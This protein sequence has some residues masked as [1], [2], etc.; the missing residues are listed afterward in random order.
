[1]ATTTSSAA[2]PDEHLARLEATARTIQKTVE[3]PATTVDDPNWHTRPH[4]LETTEHL[5]SRRAGMAE[6]ATAHDSAE[7]RWELASIDAELSRRA[8]VSPT[9]KA[10]EEVARGERPRAETGGT[11]AEGLAQEKAIR[12][13]ALPT[14]GHTLAE[15]ELGTLTHGVSGHTAGTYWLQHQHTP[16]AM[17]TILDAHHTDIGEL[18]VLRGKQLAT[19]RP[20]WAEALGEVPANPANAARWY[21]VAG[22][23]DAYRETYRI[24]DQT[25]IPKQYAESERGAYL[26]GQITDVHKRGALSHTP[27][28]DPE[29]VETTAA[30]ATRERTHRETVTPAEVAV[31]VTTEERTQA[32]EDLWDVVERDYKAEQ[33]AH[34]E[35]DAAREALEAARA[36]L[37]DSTGQREAIAEQLIETA[38]EDYAP[39]EAA[40]ARV[41]SANFF[42]RSTREADYQHALTDYRDQYGQDTPPGRDDEQWLE[43][44]HDYTAAQNEVTEDHGQLATAE[45]AAAAAERQAE[46]ATATREQ[47]YQ[48]YA[49]ARDGNPRTRVGTSRMDETQMARA[50]DLQA[51]MDQHHLAA[52]TRPGEA[53]ENSRAAAARAPRPSQATDTRT[54]RSVQQHHAQHTHRRGRSL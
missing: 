9:Q 27:G 12:D 18:A 19:E 14:T 43:R 6:G 4:A 47:S 21:R 37:Q 39:V 16:E 52:G 50:T 13:A 2:I 7:Y 35:R 36:K 8:F 25:P 38:R 31:T 28:P 3:K 42:T 32:V 5:R 22:E 48:G 20:A 26:A 23:V 40:A 24:T 49:T 29:Q 33:G 45:T 10:V 41:E 30:T 11:L 54:T 1:M 17:R 46:T 15:Q 44:H 34:T 53:R 51:T